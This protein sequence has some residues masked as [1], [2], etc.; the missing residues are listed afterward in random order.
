MAGLGASGLFRRVNLATERVQFMAAGETGVTG[1]LAP[2]HAEEAGKDE[3][4]CATTLLRLLT[5]TPVLVPDSNFGLATTS[6]VH[7]TVTELVLGTEWR[8]NT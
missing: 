1:P 6:L 4:G 5:A 7:L 3:S 8:L 2:K